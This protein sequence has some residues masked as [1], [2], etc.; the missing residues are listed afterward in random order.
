MNL[1][2]PAT[3]EIKYVPKYYWTDGHGVVLH[4][5]S[6]EVNLKVCYC[7]LALCCGCWSFPGFY[8]WWDSRSPHRRSHWICLSGPIARRCWTR[9]TLL[10]YLKGNTFFNVAVLHIPCTVGIHNKC[11]ILHTQR[12]L[13]TVENVAVRL[14]VVLDAGVQHLD[15][16]FDVVEEAVAQID[17]AVFPLSSPLLP[18]KNLNIV[19][20][21]NTCSTH[22]VKSS[23]AYPLSPPSRSFDGST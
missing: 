16:L 3:P 14:R 18:S 23:P 13:L 12:Y 15:L 17:A 22:E 8:P 2:W 1:I 10:A 20:K 6:V 7:H 9:S 21:W 5:V 19:M 4:F 11:S